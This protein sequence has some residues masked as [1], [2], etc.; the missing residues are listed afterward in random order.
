MSLLKNIKYHK[1]LI[2]TI[3]NFKESKSGKLI[4]KNEIFN[5]KEVN[6]KPHDNI[7]I[8]DFQNEVFSKKT[9]LGNFIGEHF[10]GIQIQLGRTVYILES[11]FLGNYNLSKLS[12]NVDRFHTIGFY[13]NAKYYYRLVIP[14]KKKLDFH[15]QIEQTSFKTDLGYFSRSSTTAIIDG[16]SIHAYC[17][18][19]EKNQNYFVI[20]SN[21][22][23]TFDQFINKA[24]AI[25]LGI[26]Y[27]SGYYVG[28]KGFFFA[29][30]NKIMSQPKH[31]RYIALRDS[32]RSQYCPIY[33]NA[34]GYL[35]RDKELA[36]KYQSLLRQISLVEF[37]VLC[38]KIY[39]SLELS[40]ILMLIL[41]SS[42]ASLLFM[43]GGFAIALENLSDLVIEKRKLKLSPIKDREISKKIREEI[44]VVLEKYKELMSSE[45]LATIYKR[46]DNIN[47]IT[48]KARLKAPFD[49]LTITLN[50][51]DLKILETRNDFLHGRV[52]DLTNEGLNRTLNRINKDLF[53]CSMKFYTLLNVLIL[54]W[55]GYDNRIVNYPKI[56]EDFIEIHLSE[57][58]F[59]Q[60]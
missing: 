2:K 28:N 38:D 9:F 36:E 3:E 49:L 53:Y 57:E 46:V 58:P 1:E 24:N 50:E 8:V 26:G 34:F 48:N 41:E 27:L 56:H 43:P 14:L 44:F 20:E 4:S 21:I 18:N 23:Q 37:S 59:R 11:V 30:T 17:I 31:F 32:I 55:I 45:D 19:N 6:F 22:K 25:K 5:G 13:E 12:G 40:S 54:K 60:V 47:Q 15:Y 52:P 16:E 42:N 29:Y 35:H 7:F 33:S 39:T 10:T 51:E